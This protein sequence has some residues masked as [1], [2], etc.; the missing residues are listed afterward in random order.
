LGWVEK[1]YGQTVGLDTA[2]LIYY[3]E[4]HATYLPVVDPFFEAVALPR[5]RTH[6]QL[7]HSR[8]GWI[9]V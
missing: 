3:L 7:L 4:A 6:R 5:K 9:T 1:L 2:P 8:D